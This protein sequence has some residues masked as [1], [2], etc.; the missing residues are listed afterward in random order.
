MD[1]DV[2]DPVAKAVAAVQ[3]Q[4]RVAMEA[5]AWDRKQREFAE[6]LLATSE[7]ES[8]KTRSLD[9]EAEMEAC[10]AAIMV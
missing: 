9:K 7:V 1:I 3:E 2:E 6:R 5:Q 10:S 4:L 8:Q